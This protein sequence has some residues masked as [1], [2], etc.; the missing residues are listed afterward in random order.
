M[1]G[2]LQ[3]SDEALGFTQEII[4]DMEKKG[5]AVDL[6]HQILTRYNAG[7][8]DHIK[9]I[10]VTGI[11]EI[12]GNTVL[13]LTDE[14]QVILDLD[15]GQKNIDLTG[16]NI[17]IKKIGK[18]EGNRIFFKRSALRELGELLYPV[19]AYG[20]LNGGSASSYVDSKRNKTLNED[21]FKIYQKEFETIELISKGKAKGITPAFIN[22]DGT[23][24]PSYIEL[25][26]RALLIEILRCKLRNGPKPSF[27]VFQMTSV[28]N[29]DE[30]QSTYLKYKT[31]DLL[32][33]LIEATG[34]DV[35]S[36]LTGVQPM[37]A[38][39]T[40]DSK[41]KPKRIFSEAYGVP[42]N[43]LPMP[44]GH[45]QNFQIL[46][47]IY[48]D[49]KDR[50]FK[51]VY[52]GN[53]DNL[54]FTVDPIS[55]ALIALYHKEAG[56]EFSFR[57]VV[58]IKGGILIR[59]QY[60]RLNCAD[61]GTAISK[62]EVLKAEQSGKKILFNCA[63]GLFNLD[64]LVPNIDRIIDNLPVRFSNQDKDPG[65]YAQAEQVTWEIIGMMDD[66][67]I[68]GIDKY[69]RFLAAK[70]LLE[71]LMTSGVGLD[72][73]EFPTDPDPEKDLKSVALKLHEGLVRK[74]NTV[75]GMKLIKGHWVPRSLEELKA[76]L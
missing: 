32:Q 37:L 31:S 7:L 23:P 11:P 44:G 19:V 53:V 5:I 2:I 56:F 20:F 8:Y 59:D 69:D 4:G 63:T 25:K 34:V 28:Y 60:N 52:L 72:N 62:N 15:E 74:L 46:K 10:Q 6:T 65:M 76:E 49:L 71:G 9:P 55:V 17:D 26:M 27:P 36:V 73:P 61:I 67:L 48:Q 21:L 24:G 50:G 64:Y 12:D 51:Y 14:L 22:P 70:M 43:T 68:F 66:F 54:G 58:D 41:G 30:V 47:T 29:N 40:H 38:A 1:A 13:D 45:G 18:V 75:Y 16:L 33:T 57:T 42:N 35:T 39:Y 3:I